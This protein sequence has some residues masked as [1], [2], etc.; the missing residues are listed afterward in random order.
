MKTPEEML[1][2]IVDDADQAG[3]ICRVRAGLIAEARDVLAK[4]NKER[5]EAIARA[6]DVF[7]YDEVVPGPEECSLLPLREFAILMAHGALGP[8]DGLGHYA[9]D[10]KLA[11]STDV[12]SQSSRDATHVAWFNK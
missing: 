12:F 10:G 6:T 7:V 2:A 9:K 5:E 11:S 8:D 3:W 4:A 1:R